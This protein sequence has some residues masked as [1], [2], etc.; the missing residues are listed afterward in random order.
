MRDTN[1]VLC[2][3]TFWAAA[4]LLAASIPS[5]AI[6]QG[7]KIHFGSPFA[8]SETVRLPG[9]VVANHAFAMA[10]H[11]QIGA[12]A[13]DVQ[14]ALPPLTESTYLGAW[15]W[16]S[17]DSRH[18]RRL[19]DGTF[20]IA[21]SNLSGQF[22]RDDRCWITQWPYLQ[23]N[24]GVARHMSAPTPELLFL[25]GIEYRRRMKNRGELQ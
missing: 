6:A 16:V 21:M 19:E 8:V 11:R 1:S 24:N 25:D 17:A 2:S 14:A 9:S 13:P 18:V 3:R 5:L 4:L 23:C 12:A 10:M 15:L 20:L 7:T 22:H